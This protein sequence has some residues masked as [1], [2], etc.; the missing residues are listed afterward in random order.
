MEVTIS[1]LE[2][3][4]ERERRM[5]RPV[6]EKEKKPNEKVGD[7]PT[8]FNGDVAIYREKSP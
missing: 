2:I 3:I 4:I 8:Q 6:K 5:A 7:G 1:C